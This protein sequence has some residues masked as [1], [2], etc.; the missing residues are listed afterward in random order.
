MVF[1]EKRFNWWHLAFVPLA[2]GERGNFFHFS[3]WGHF[4]GLKKRESTLEGG[5]KAS[6]WLPALLLWPSATKADPC[7][8]ASRLLGALCQQSTSFNSAFQSIILH[9]FPFIL[10]TWEPVILPKSLTSTWLQEHFGF[11]AV[12]TVYQTEPPLE[13]LKHV[14]SS[15]TSSEWLFGH[16]CGLTFSPFALTYY[17]CVCE[18]NI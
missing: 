2:Y 12:S 13:E 7:Y 17:G 5:S 6:P 18:S 11:R 4:G 8:F 14:H 1:V 15:V 3:C 10:L 9:L 16:T